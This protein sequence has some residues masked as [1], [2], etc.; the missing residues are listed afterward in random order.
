MSFFQLVANEIGWS[1]DV[2]RGIHKNQLDTLSAL[3]WLADD[4]RE[5]F[6]GLV[7]LF[8]LGSEDILAFEKVNVWA[9]DDRN[10][11][12]VEEIKTILLTVG[13]K[14]RSLYQ[15]KTAIEEAQQ[16]FYPAQIAP[17][18][19][20]S[21]DL[22]AG[23]RLPFLT[24]DRI[25][26]WGDSREGKIVDRVRIAGGYLPSHSSVKPVVAVKTAVAAKLRKEKI[27]LIELVACELRPDSIMICLGAAR[28]GDELSIV[29]ELAICDLEMILY[30]Q[31]DAD[32]I[33][34][35]PRQDQLIGPSYL[36]SGSLDIAK[37]LEWLHQ[38][39]PSSGHQ[40]RECFHLDLKPSNIL[41]F[42]D[43]Q[44]W[45]WKI[46]DFGEASI[47]VHEEN[48]IYGENTPSTREKR[49]ADVYLPPEVEDGHVGRACDIWSFGCILLDILAYV[50]DPRE[51]VKS[52]QDLRRE[53]RGTNSTKIEAAFY[54]RRGG[55]GEPLLKQQLIDKFQD[56]PVFGVQWTSPFKATL[57]KLLR[58]DRNERPS[59]TEVKI[60]IEALFKQFGKDAHSEILPSDLQKQASGSFALDSIPKSIDSISTPA[61]T[62][63]YTSPEEAK[64]FIISDS[65][66]WLVHKSLKSVSSLSLGKTTLWE[67][68]KGQWQS[69][70]EG[71][72]QLAMVKFFSVSGNYL[73]ILGAGGS[74]VD[75]KAGFL[76]TVHHLGQGGRSRSTSVRYKSSPIG[77]SV[78][79]E[80]KLLVHFM[81]HVWL[82]YPGSLES[83]S[84][85]KKELGS[86]ELRAACFSGDGNY[87][88]AWAAENQ[89]IHGKRT[90]SRSWF[91]W[92]LKN[93]RSESSS[94]YLTCQTEWEND[95]HSIIRVPCNDVMVP[96]DGTPYRFAKDVPEGDAVLLHFMSFDR[97][98]NVTLVYSQSDTLYSYKLRN[99]ITGVYQARAWL[100]EDKQK[101]ILVRRKPSSGFQVYSVQQFDI[102]A[103]T[104]PSRSPETPEP[105]AEFTD[106]QML[107]SLVK[108]YK[109]EH[110]GLVLNVSATGS[111]AYAFGNEGGKTVVRK[112]KLL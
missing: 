107:T 22:P 58:V 20:T 44:S 24:R 39:I 25:Y 3:V 30:Q 50:C 108:N 28:I 98:G 75:Y 96:L 16:I 59:A 79:C 51:G 92:K 37:G 106:V 35:L 72:A 60:E 81:N 67:D 74:N 95:R 49:G 99:P 47:G 6:V 80:G 46:T 91:V 52:L 31:L 1:Q 27:A 2:K 54:G 73:A 4:D 23:R 85:C 8:R 42:G 55:T 12:A 53:D 48:A 21:R 105:K 65:G 93:P 61:W 82:H 110:I 94:D 38:K 86:S 43:D 64:T 101:I 18:A 78:S 77:L 26:P 13:R 19:E 41:A 11:K 33:K 34:R 111:M 66:Q 15:I 70:L 100:Q 69:C 84:S 97:S 5:S 32:S 87:V 68:T 90:R 104:I 29:F 109:G 62:K 56:L 63:K 40:S 57:F 45:I 89:E 88:Y 9:S 14:K 71:A 10:C 102:P 76:I 36:L 83:L 112:A 17:I 7:G 103:P